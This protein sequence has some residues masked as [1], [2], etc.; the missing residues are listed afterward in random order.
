MVPPLEAII[1][2]LRMYPP[3]LA[4]EERMSTGPLCQVEL[5]GTLPRPPRPGILYVP[6]GVPLRA[7]PCQRDLKSSRETCRVSLA[8]VLVLD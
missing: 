4:R 6:I 3:T 8:G 1:R 2:F 7:K 5:I